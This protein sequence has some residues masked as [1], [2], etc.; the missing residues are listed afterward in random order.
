MLYLLEQRLQLSYSIAMENFLKRF[1]K[2]IRYYRELNNYSQEELADLIGVSTNTL[3]SWERG[4][5]FIRTITLEKLSKE[6]KIKPEF[7]FS[8]FEEIFNTK[9]N[10]LLEEILQCMLTLSTSQ[11]QQLL[12]I[13]KTFK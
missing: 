7:L 13:I 2:K 1:G 10:P 12:K 6:L 3:A 4:E 11:Q 9:D 5:S 8:T